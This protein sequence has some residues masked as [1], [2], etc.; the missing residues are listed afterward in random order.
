MW[1]ASREPLAGGGSR[2]VSSFERELDLGLTVLH[3]LP[4]WSCGGFRCILSLIISSAMDV[5]KTCLVLS[6][7]DTTGAL[8]SSTGQ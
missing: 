4:F 3:P 6:R 1:D 8:F 7:G 5:A 2:E